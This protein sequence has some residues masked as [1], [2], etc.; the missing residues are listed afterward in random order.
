MSSAAPQK[1]ICVFFGGCSSKCFQPV[2]HPFRTVTVFC[3]AF[4]VFLASPSSP[5]FGCCASSSSSSSS[6]LCRKTKSTRITRT[7]YFCLCNETIYSQH[8]IARAES[9]Q[10]KRHRMMRVSIWVVPFFLPVVKRERERESAVFMSSSFPACVTK[11][12]TFFSNFVI[13]ERGRKRA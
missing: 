12:S 1:I 6:P 3:N 7:I 10:N 11:V 5:R 8:T 13:E 9:S 4:S 2:L